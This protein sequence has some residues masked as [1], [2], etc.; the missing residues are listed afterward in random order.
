MKHYFYL[1]KKRENHKGVCP[2]VCRIADAHGRRDFRTGLWTTPD[3]WDNKR[4]WPKANMQSIVSRLIII[5]NDVSSVIFDCERD[6]VRNIHEVVLRYKELHKPILSTLDAIGKKYI[7]ETKPSEVVATRIELAIAQF[8]TE[9]GVVTINR[10]QPEV[11]KQY[12]RALLALKMSPAWV[13][14]KLGYIKRLTVY[15]EHKKYISS[16]PFCMY[17]F[18][19]IGKPVLI[20][21]TA[22][23]LKTLQLHTFASDRLNFVKEL[24]LFQCYTGLSYADLTQFSRSSIIG[25]HDIK[26]LKGERMKTGEEYFLP[27]TKEAL[28]IAEKHNYCFRSLSNQKYNA[29]LKEVAQILGIDKK[30]TTHVGRK[31]FAQSMIDKGYSAE[32]VSK[33]MGHA[34]FNMTQKHYGRIGEK[35][36]EMEFLKLAS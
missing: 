27:W 6:K 14:K 32:A 34:S 35:R 19:V 23:E 29:Y 30:L 26:Y 11:I 13:C 16:N 24:F 22:K 36:I 8:K 4:S 21:L 33:M 9:T 15:S 17:K 28:A 20:Q 25:M 18:P 7:E 12:E 1:S 31:T 5:Q 3:N 2:I 10:I